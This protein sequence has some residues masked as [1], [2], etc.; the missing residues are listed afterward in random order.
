MSGDAPRDEEVFQLWLLL[1]WIVVE[2]AC[3]LALAEQIVAG[4]L[5]LALILAGLAGFAGWRALVEWPG[6]G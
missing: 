1:F 6:E 5:P 3:S 4:D 2:V